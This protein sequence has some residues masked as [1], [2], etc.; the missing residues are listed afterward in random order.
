M[1]KKNVFRLCQKLL[2]SLYK[3]PT[4]KIGDIPLGRSSWKN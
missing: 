3:G 4:A 1:D 2:E